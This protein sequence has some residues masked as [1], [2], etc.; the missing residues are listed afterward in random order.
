MDLGAKANKQTSF[1]SHADP[2]AMRRA[3]DY[4]DQ[5]FHSENSEL[6]VFYLCTGKTRHYDDNGVPYAAPKVCGCCTSSK[7]WKTLFED[8]CAVGQ[9]WYCP[10]PKSGLDDGCP[11]RYMT[12][13]G[14]LVEIRLG[15]GDQAR[16]Y[17]ARAEFLDPIT[18]KSY[19]IG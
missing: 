9:R 17:Y 7:W 1:S 13:M 5:W 6:N 15:T 3:A 16:W 14:H 4:A 11:K 19:G 8:P 12:R 10:R 2:E 18:I